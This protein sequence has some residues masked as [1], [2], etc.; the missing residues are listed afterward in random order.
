MSTKFGVLVDGKYEEVAFR[1]NYSRGTRW[2]NPIAKLLPDE[3]ELAALD[4]TPQ[5]IYTIG[6]FKE[7]LK[8]DNKGE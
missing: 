3:T 7:A 1:G 8:H 6:E 2:L 5:G 4:N